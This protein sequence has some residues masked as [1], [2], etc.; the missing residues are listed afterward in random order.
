MKKTYNIKNIFKEYES[1]RYNLYRIY[2][3][4]DNHI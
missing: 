1:Y 4:F 3:E 2:R